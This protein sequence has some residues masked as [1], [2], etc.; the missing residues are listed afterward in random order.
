MAVAVCKLC[1]AVVVLCITDSTRCSWYKANKSLSSWSLDCIQ[2]QVERNWSSF[3]RGQWWSD[4]LLI[5]VS[6]MLTHYCFICVSI[7]I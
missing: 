1:S 7:T 4:G 3:K 2:N 6:W 5:R